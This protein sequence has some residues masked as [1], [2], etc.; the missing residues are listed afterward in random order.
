MKLSLNCL[1]V[2]EYICVIEFKI[3]EDSRSGPVVNELRTLIEEGT[4]VLIS[5]YDK[6]CRV[7]NISRARQVI[8]YPADKITWLH[9]RILEY[10]S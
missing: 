5:F 9:A 1:E 2:V 3:V 6:K 8:R 10:P 4:I 7:T